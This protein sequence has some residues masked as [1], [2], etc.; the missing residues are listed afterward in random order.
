MFKYHHIKSC[1]AANLLLIEFFKCV[2]NGT[3]NAIP[4]KGNSLKIEI[5]LLLNEL[6]EFEFYGIRNRLMNSLTWRIIP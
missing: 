5:R 1:I 2:Y 6:M 4:A 3:Q